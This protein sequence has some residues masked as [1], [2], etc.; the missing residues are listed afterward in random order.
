LLVGGR[1]WSTELGRD[2]TP[3][4]TSTPTFTGT[5]DSTRPLTPS[6]RP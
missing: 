5:G 2:T 3:L 1:I 6:S 4:T